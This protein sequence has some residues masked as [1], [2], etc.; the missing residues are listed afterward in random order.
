M[1]PVETKASGDERNWPRF[2][3]LLYFLIAGVAAWQT[4]QHTSA[5]THYFDQILNSANAQSL[6]RLNL[7]HPI[8]G[9]IISPSI[10]QYLGLASP[11]KLSPEL[12]T[13]I[14]HL[15]QS[16]KREA[17]IAAW[18]SWFLF[19]ISLI[20]IVAVIVS[21]SNLRVRNVLF[22]LT[23]VSTIFFVVGIAA[24]A[25][26][27]FTIPNVPSISLSF[28]LQHEVRSIFSAIVGLFS[29]GHW[30]IGGLITLF[31]I[32]TPFTKTFLT[33]IAITTKSPSVSSRI[34]RFLHTI[35][36]WSMADV[37]V[38]AVFLAC[39]ALTT[40][41]ATKAIP[42]RG[43]YYFAG[44]CL[45]SMVTTLL[46]ANLNVTSENEPP[47]LGKQLGVAVTGG[48][49]GAVL[50]LII[51]AGI[52]TFE[53]HPVPAVPTELNNSQVNLQAHHWQKIPLSVPHPGT[54]SIELRVMLG[55]PVDVALIPA[56][57]LS[58]VEQANGV[59]QAGN[60]LRASL[61]TFRAVQARIYNH[62]GQIDKG[63]FL[64]V[65]QDTTLGIL[66]APASDIKIQ[67]Y[68]KP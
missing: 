3:A 8:I 37:F 25:M 15:A 41:E 52:Y 39:F 57:Q 67:A 49:F 26:V 17:S 12:G 31:S 22:A 40:L 68:L 23:S 66:S 64:I 29:S 4:I 56:D 58:N 14:P 47:K 24:P 44:Y 28:V 20:Y 32:I 18:W 10:K 5:A 65:L 59:I 63:D 6:T 16:L 46:L 51:V 62:T 21:H 38:A 9:P 30:I 43:L 42:C 48:L 1:H 50:F 34:A 55:N 61:P 45:L 13:E 60:L 53:K 36:K 27:I 33:I 19:S 35:G 54:L 11:R 2:F 7:Q